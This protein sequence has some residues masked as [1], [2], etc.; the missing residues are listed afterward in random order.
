MFANETLI[1]LHKAEAPHSSAN[2]PTT[3][4][5]T[6]SHFRGVESPRKPFKGNI[7]RF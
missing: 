1:S 5:A 7:L 3:I 4:G 6:L 2:S